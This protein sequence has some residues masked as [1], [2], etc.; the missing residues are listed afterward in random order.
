MIPESVST[1][2]LSYIPSNVMGAPS[3]FVITT[4]KAFN[5]VPKNKNDYLSNWSS[6]ISAEI[7]KTNCA[8]LICLIKVLA[9]YLGTS[10]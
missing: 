4:P 1:Q 6:L 3:I 7:Y 9:P 2:S 8:I 10:T 5:I